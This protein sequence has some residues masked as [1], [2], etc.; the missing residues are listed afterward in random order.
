MFTKQY[1]LGNL[2][3]LRIKFQNYFIE[4][5]VKTSQKYFVTKSISTL[6]NN[7]YHENL[8]IISDWRD[9][10]NDKPIKIFVQSQQVNIIM[11]ESLL[12]E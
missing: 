12:L 7:V 4:K 3:K 2:K 11:N 6:I 10:T 8:L 1:Y 9:A 5:N